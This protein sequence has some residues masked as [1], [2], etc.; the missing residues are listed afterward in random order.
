MCLPRGVGRDEHGARHA[1][2]PVCAP[3][4]AAQEG[5]R[6]AAQRLDRFEQRGRALAR[7]G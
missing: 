6:E 7:E 3:V 5:V 1:Q 2:R 4:A